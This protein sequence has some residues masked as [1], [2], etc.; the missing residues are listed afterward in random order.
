MSSG[1]ETVPACGGTCFEAFVSSAQWE[2]REEGINGVK[3]I[4][5]YVGSFPET[6]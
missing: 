1:E 6:A 3:M 4:R 2:R 5:G